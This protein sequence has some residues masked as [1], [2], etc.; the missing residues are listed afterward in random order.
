VRQAI[1]T[2][3]SP[4]GR[5]LADRGYLNER[6]R[7]FNPKSVRAM[8]SAEARAA[9]D[10]PLTAHRL[11]GVGLVSPFIRPGPLRRFFSG[12]RH[13]GERQH[14]KQEFRLRLASQKAAY[15][16]RSSSRMQGH[17]EKWLWCM[18]SSA[19]VAIS[20]QFLAGVT[21]ASRTS[22]SGQL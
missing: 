20:D 1:L 19:S 22:S 8:I 12:H 14:R 5:M 21:V 9:R 7:P 10:R 11:D 2:W 15:S 3:H 4:I 16:G 6:N 17:K 18:T 13:A